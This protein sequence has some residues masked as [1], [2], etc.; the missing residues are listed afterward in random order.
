[1]NQRVKTLARPKLELSSRA[2]MGCVIMDFSWWFNIFGSGTAEELI[3]NRMGLAGWANKKKS[4][5]SRG[6]VTHSNKCW[7]GKP[8][9]ALISLPFPLMWGA[10]FLS[11]E[12]FFEFL[13][14]HDLWVHSYIRFL[15]PRSFWKIWKWKIFQNEWN[16]SPGYKKLLHCPPLSFLETSFRHHLIK[17]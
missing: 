3:R 15:I 9:V 7:I 2:N 5:F 6:D 8:Q 10:S 14:A 17:K 11:Y 4:I 1:M 13:I 16:S 12:Y